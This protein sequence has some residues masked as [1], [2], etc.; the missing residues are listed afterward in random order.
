MTSTGCCGP[1]AGSGSTTP[2]LRRTGTAVRR[3]LS[4]AAV[5]G[6][7][8][9]T[10][11]SPVRLFARLAVDPWLEVRRCAEADQ[12]ERTAVGVPV[13]AALS[14]L[15]RGARGHGEVSAPASILAW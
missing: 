5:H 13:R 15:W 8:V 7:P 10:R 14:G 6:A 2:A 3:V 11:R 12:A 1:T 9:H 4:A